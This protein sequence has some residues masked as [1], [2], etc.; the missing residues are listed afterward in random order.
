[1]FADMQL[2]DRIRYIAGLGRS[3]LQSS[4]VTIGI[5][6][7]TLQ[8]AAREKDESARSGREGMDST[9]CRDLVLPDSG[10]VEW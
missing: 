8:R 6:R 5:F 4:C 10:D 7:E 3:A 9:G 1:M 2:Y